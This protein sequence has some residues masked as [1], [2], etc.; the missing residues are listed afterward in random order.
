MEYGLD[1]KKI[2]V[3][4]DLSDN[5]LVAVQ[6][7]NKIAKGCGAKVYLI[8]VLADIGAPIG[9]IPDI[10]FADIENKIREDA[11]KRLEHLRLRELG[12][13]ADVEIVILKGNPANEIV[14][15]ADKNDIDMIVIATTGKHG[16]EKL[17]LGSVAEKVTKKSKM[18]V[19]VAKANQLS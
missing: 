6:S 13:T 1:L 18:S 4:T 9:Y 12:D 5:S 19:L 17:L 15:F 16:L 7:A 14:E 10:S 3:T 8:H 2:A 11:S